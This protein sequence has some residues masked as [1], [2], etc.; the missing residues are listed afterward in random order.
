MRSLSLQMSQAEYDALIAVLTSAPDWDVA[1]TLVPKLTDAW[2]AASPP[3][4][5]AE[6]LVMPLG[7]QRSHAVAE[8]S[9]L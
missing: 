4:P 3:H 8:A 2:T 6:D 7:V 9:P 5:L 1:Q